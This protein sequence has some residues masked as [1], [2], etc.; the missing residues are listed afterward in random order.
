M[1]ENNNNQ[2]NQNFNQQYQ[3]QQYQP[4]KPPKTPKEPFVDIALEKTKKRLGK[5]IPLFLVLIVAGVLYSNSFVVTKPN[6]YTMIQQFG[7]VVSVRDEPGLSFKIPFVQNAKTIPNTVLLYDLPISDVITKDKKTMVADSFVLWKVSDPLTFIQTLHG[8]V[9]NAEARISTIVYNSMKNVISNLS[10]TEIISGRDTL[11][12]SIFANI[13]DGLDKYGIELVAVET[14]RLDLPDDNK[15]AVYERMISERNN[16][17]A[18]Y[19]A[20]GESEATK[21]RSETDKTISIQIAQ[22]EAQAAKI[23]AEGEAEYM[24]ILSEAYADESRA[25]FY[26]FVRSLDAAKLSMSGDNKTLILTPDSPLAQ[27]FYNAQ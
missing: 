1:N 13:G 26:S 23:E 18:S 10:Q 3:Y 27:I 24:R 25:D 16:I 19:Q 14:K 12:Q 4:P 7:K 22:A 21:I 9:S 8:N 11:A 6:Q 2:Y 15:Q 5:L 17:A 20:E